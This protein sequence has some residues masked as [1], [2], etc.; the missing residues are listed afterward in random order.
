[1]ELATSDVI[2]GREIEHLGLVQGNIVLTRH[3]GQDIMAGLKAIVG[4]ELTQ[5]T[6]LLKESRATATERMI[7]E[8]KDMGADAIVTVRYF[9]SD[10]MQMASEVMVSGTAVKFK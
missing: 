2:A 3:I 9:T 6:D 4:G 7:Q 10:I 1:M 5:F 8:A